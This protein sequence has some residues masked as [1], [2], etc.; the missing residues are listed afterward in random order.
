MLFTI[1]RRIC[2]IHEQNSGAE[3][4]SRMDAQN[5]RRVRVMTL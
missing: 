3:F 2:I 4:M 1:Q 5:M